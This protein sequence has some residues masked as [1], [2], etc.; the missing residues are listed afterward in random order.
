MRGFER[1]RRP[2]LWEMLVS[3]VVGFGAGQAVFR[4]IADAQRAETR[5]Y[6]LGA[7]DGEH[8]INSSG[9]VVIKVDPSRGSEKVSL[10]TQQVP[11]GA[12]I[13]RHR[14]TYE[15]EFFYV[16]EGSGTVIL[17][18]ERLP[19]QKGATIFIPKGTWHAFENPGSA[20][21]LLWVATT[22][23]QEDYFRGIS[24]LPGEPFRQ[25][26]PEQKVAIRQQ[27]EAE[28]LKRIQSH[29]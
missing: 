24:S 5:G 20:L 28:Q 23:G 6:V 11:P 13:P 25:L 15:D 3:S 16:L 18:D 1:R 27:V 26:T 10:G 21:L 29:P 4:N 7:A 9:D 8:L 19:L 14:H 2:M 17:N 12:G 22:T